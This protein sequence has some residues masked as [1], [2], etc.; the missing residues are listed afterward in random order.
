[1]EVDSE[2][3]D[4]IANANVG[5]SEVSEYDRIDDEIKE[6]AKYNYSFDNADFSTGLQNLIDHLY[7]LRRNDK[8]DDSSSLFK[9][10]GTIFKI[11]GRSVILE[12]FDYVDE[13]GGTGT[14]NN[15]AKVLLVDEFSNSLILISPILT[16]LNSVGLMNV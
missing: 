1:M 6:L 16:L 9:Y 8:S 12:L 5:Y 13:K 2:N 3:L 15:H 4:D 7:N 10:K 11:C 14:Y